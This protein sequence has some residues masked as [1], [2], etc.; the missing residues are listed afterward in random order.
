MSPILREFR[1]VIIHTGLISLGINLL[2]LVP[3][4][5]M[6]LIYDRVVTGR[7]EETLVVLSL[8]AVIALLFM[9][10]LD[11]VRARL[12]AHSGVAVDR[13]LGP[14]VL[15]G[16]LAQ[17]ARLTG[18]DYGQ[19]LRNIA[20]LRG[21][22]AGPGIMALF[23]APWL[24]IYLVIIFLFHPLLGAVA[25]TGMIILLI[26][27]YAS[28]RLSRP[29]LE[30]M[31]KE[32]RSA[33]RFIDAGLRNAEVLS[34][35]G[36]RTNL[37]AHWEDRN[38]QVLT[39]QGE[40]SRLNVAM[41]SSGRAVR[42][43]LQIVMLGTGAYLSLGNNVAPGIM[44]AATILLGRSLQPLESILS[45]WKSLTEARSALRQLTDML[46]KEE[47]QAPPTSLPAP[48]GNL[49]VERLVFGFNPGEKAI[50]KG[51]SFELEAGTSLAIIGPSGSG[52][53]TLARLLVGLWRP[54]SGVVRIDGADITQ[55]SREALGPYLGYV[56]Q[57][58]EL[59]AST[60]AENIARLGTVDGEKVVEAARRAHA[61]E[62]IL[63][64][65]KGYDTFLGEGGGLISAGQRQRI[66]LARAL[67][68]HPKL[69]IMD[70]P[71]SNLDADGESALLEAMNELKRA[72]ITQI[73]ITHRPTLLSAVD[74]V[75][76]LKDGAVELLGPRAEVLAKITRPAS[77]S[78]QLK[79]VEGAA[80]PV[81]GP[82]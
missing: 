18:E 19:S 2:L 59:F 71:N 8:G 70:E 3:S 14:R 31:A 73:L 62:F 60:V 58:V 80:A 30:K 17:A 4:F 6:L 34:A 23:D 66:A 74:Q 28:E 27:T 35:L 5:Y 55:W 36:M 56:P 81:A 77:P 37:A 43:I 54:A 21:F 39:R 40:V 51:V 32:S 75:L 25:L 26:M 9:Y 16:V 72:G 10:A 1:P 20:T 12:L 76:V 11:Y 42:Q 22:L 47:R 29:L 67:Y 68:G 24:P 65:P 82:G 41:T 69:V 63:R 38:G 45:G 48:V 15:A 46:G 79:V 78:G 57:D 52:K 61:H 33:S 44:L 7:S 49:S 53:S 50:I 64:L 13:I